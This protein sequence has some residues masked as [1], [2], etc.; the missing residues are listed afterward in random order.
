MRK[1]RCIINERRIVFVSNLNVVYWL[2]IRVWLS[3]MERGFVELA[4]RELLIEKKIFY[5]VY[6]NH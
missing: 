6:E 2:H 3:D 1:E 5:Y 4:V